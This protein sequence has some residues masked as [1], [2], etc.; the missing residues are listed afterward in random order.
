MFF[1]T[2]FYTMKHFKRQ[3]RFISD[4]P[5][6]FDG[7]DTCQHNNCDASVN[8]VY[9]GDSVKRNFIVAGNSHIS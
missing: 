8:N 6:I 1:E 9:N 5:N 3:H 7:D 2:F 4:E